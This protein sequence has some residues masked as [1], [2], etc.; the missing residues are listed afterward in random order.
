MIGEY[1]QMNNRNSLIALSFLREVE[2]P[3]EIF[4]NY[5]EYCLLNFKGHMASYEKLLDSFKN[6]SGLNIPNYIFSHCL[7]IMFSK[8]A[9]EKRNNGTMYYLI[10]QT[11]D[12]SKFKTKTKLLER[13]E[14][15]LLSDLVSFVKEYNK[16]WTIKEAKNYLCDL[17]L[18][19][20]NV[21]S[22][23]NEEK[24]H[25][26]FDESTNEWLVQKYIRNIYE[27]KDVYYDYLMDIVQGLVVYVGTLYTNPNNNINIVNTDFYFDTKLILR[28]LGYTSDVYH[29]SVTQLIDLIR[30]IYNGNIC[31][32]RHTVKEIESALYNASKNLSNNTEIDDNELRIYSKLK[33]ID[34][35]DFRVF[36]DSVEQDLIN[37]GI[38]IQEEIAWENRDCWIDAIQEDVLFDEIKKTRKIYK[39]QSIKND[40]NAINQINMLRKGDY[41]VHFGG[42]NALPIIVTNNSV[43]IKCIKNFILKDLETDSNSTWKIGRMPI[44]SDTAL[45][46][47]LWSN[48]SNKNIE[49]PELLFSK[50]AHA[51]LQYDDSFFDN[52]RERSKIL[53]EKYKC[54]IFNLSVERMEKIESLIIKNNNGNIEGLSDEDIIFTIEESYKADK[55]YL[56]KEVAEKE[57]IIS[58]QTAI[59]VEKEQ[60]IETKKQQLI[61]AYSKKYINDFGLYYLLIIISNYWWIISTLI[62][63]LISFCIPNIESNKIS[64][65]GI[66]CIISLLP[67]VYKLI[68]EILKKFVSRK[69]VTDKINIICMNKVR[70]GYIKRLRNSLSDEERTYEEEIIDYCLNNAKYL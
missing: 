42:E 12:L 17:L 67:L 13:Q 60:E 6:N 31:V 1:I 64:N 65:L 34:S 22:I 35:D 15:D 18:A 7:K 58:E 44:I 8:K 45:M 46:C 25:K 4:C 56:Q 70:N 53:N 33:N 43:F 40:V 26:N 38:R 61:Q 37:N 11:L 51:I 66:K 41:S 14:Q 47:T 5:I 10:N 29:Q 20:D 49:I 39:E 27:S 3:Y 52:L 63:A 28:F 69:E 50:N 68:I 59:I 54:K 57:N 2:N 21:Y 19:D 32:F 36:S 48:T 30:K 62:L 16:S 9:I 55:M 24:P 23:F